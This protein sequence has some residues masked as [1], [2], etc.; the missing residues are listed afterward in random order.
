MLNYCASQSVASIETKLNCK[1]ADVQYIQ[2]MHRVQL[3]SNQLLC[4]FQAVILLYEFYCY[5]FLKNIFIT[6]CDTK[7]E[8]NVYCF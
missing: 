5:M 2:Y 7:L 6:I 1:P 8:T 3:S 4:S